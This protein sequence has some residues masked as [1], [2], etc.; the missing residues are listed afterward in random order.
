MNGTQRRVLALTAVSAWLTIDMIRASGPLISHL[1]DV[2]VLIAAGS[3]IMAYAAGGIAAGV[4]V[5][6]IRFLGGARI[7]VAAI[8]V[9]VA[10]R[11]IW[12]L[13]G[14][15]QLVGVGLLTLS[16]SLALT[17]TAVRAM[18]AAGA[19]PY[20]FVALSAGGMLAVLEQVLLR[21][22]DAVWR[23]DAAGIAVTVVQV[24][25]LLAAAWWCRNASFSGSLRSFV[26]IGVW[27][28]IMVFAGANVAFWT[29]QYGLTIPEAGAIAT[30]ALA[31]AMIASLVPLPGRVRTVGLGASAVVGTW[32]AL[33][34][35]D[36]GEQTDST[37]AF[38]LG[39]AVI[40]LTVLAQGSLRPGAGSAIRLTA[41]GALFG[42]VVLLP[43]MLVQ[44]DYDIH[45]GVDHLLV[46]TIAVALFAVVTVVRNSSAVTTPAVSGRSPIM[47]LVSG[48]ALIAL[49][50][51]SGNLVEPTKRDT[52]ALGN[53]LTVMSWNIHYGVVPDVG[54][55]PNVDIDAIVTE[56]E[57]VDPDILVV[58]E[59]VRG[60]LLA[61]GIDS[62]E[63]LAGELGMSY[64]YAPAHDRQF[65]NAILSRYPLG[66]HAVH[67]TYGE[68]PQRRSAINGSITGTWEVP[69]VTNV[70][71]QHKDDEATREQQIA[72]LF[73][74]RDFVPGPI[75]A[76]DFNAL[77]GSRTVQAMLDAG[78]VSAQDEFGVESVTYVP[79]GIRIDYIFVKGYEVLD[80]FVVDTNVSDHR[81]LVITVALD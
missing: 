77:P 43:F 2:G 56:I 53:T 34:I 37:L 19:I 30:A 75:V 68:G 80:F 39:L 55:G 79:D 18:S 49:V 29:S 10:L 26:P 69:T 6:V 4:L 46:P 58:Q 17:L 5:P 44:L 42:V 22:W 64:V 70:H 38:A 45:L 48:I 23:T 81:P 54:G 31:A 7:V 13:L 50:Y 12:P 76:G 28:S 27:L 67:L 51:A 35:P 72:S 52:P 3:A 9:L 1:F 61:G 40:S 36:L 59:G 24:T 32:V 66:S 15:Y 78:Y 57:Q 21:T 63:L 14:G 71:L 47:A 25:L 11:L 16:L 73:G 41:S 60:W 74:Q 20:V 62:V 8:A 65:G 33:S